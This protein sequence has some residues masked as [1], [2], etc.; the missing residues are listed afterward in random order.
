MEVGSATAADALKPAG[1]RFRCK[2][3]ISARPTSPSPLKSP[4]SKLLAV[5]EIPYDAT[6][7]ATSA[8]STKPSRLISPGVRVYGTE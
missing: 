5:V 1:E 8:V 7:S 2:I 3:A 6:S 4:R